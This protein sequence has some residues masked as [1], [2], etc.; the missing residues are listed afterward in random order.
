M[1]HRHRKKKGISFSTAMLL[2]ILL[3]A[4]SFTAYKII[5]SGTL[6]KF[7]SGIS[8]EIGHLSSAPSDKVTSDAGSTPSD[9]A[10]FTTG[11]GSADKA[12]AI[13]S[14]TPA[15]YLDPTPA[16]TPESAATPTSAARSTPASASTPESAPTPM[17]ASTSASTSASNPS[18][19]AGSLSNPAIAATGAPATEPSV[20]DSAPVLPID[21][22]KPELHFSSKVVNPGDYI[23]LYIDNINESAVISIS[24]KLSG[25]QPTFFEYDNGKIAIFPISY[26]TIP[27]SYNFHVTIKQ[28]GKVLIDEKNQINVLKKDFPTEHMTVSKELLQKKSDEAVNHDAEYTGRAKSV[29]SPVPL[30]NGAFVM[31]A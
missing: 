10:V 5:D 4:I 16:S 7:F 18:T 1:Q 27:G 17:P 29:T 8:R 30:W 20:S 12:S 22:N 14:T 2:L 9:N 31:P 13:T 21:P 6:A 15:T 26:F 24:S 25:T 28:S 3:I 19:A 11:S 23:I